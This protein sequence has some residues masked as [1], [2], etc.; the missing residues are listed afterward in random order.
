MTVSAENLIP[1]IKC[2]L[3]GRHEGENIY[4][5]IYIP[6]YNLSKGRYSKDRKK[7]SMCSLCL[8]VSASASV[9]LSLSLSHT[10]TNTHTYTTYAKP[11]VHIQITKCSNKKKSS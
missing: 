4:R 2:H 7:V 10:H 11:D 5:Y 3:S 6:I 1:L 8:S 9:S